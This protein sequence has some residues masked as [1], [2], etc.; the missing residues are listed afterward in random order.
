MPYGVHSN[1][2]VGLA[3]PRDERSV[4]DDVTV[5]VLSH[6]GKVRGRWFGEGVPRRLMGDWSV[7]LGR[8]MGCGLGKKWNSPGKLRRCRFTPRS[9]SSPSNA[10]QRVRISADSR[11]RPF[12]R[13]YPALGPSRAN[14][15][16]W[17]NRVH[18][19]APRDCTYTISSSPR[20][21]KYPA[22]AIWSTLSPLPGPHVVTRILR[23][24]GQDCAEPT[25]YRK[26]RTQAG[27]SAIINHE[28]IEPF[29]DRSGMANSSRSTA[30]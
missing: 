28:G 13:S 12:V 4:R 26:R 5:F 9:S 25:W 14:P 19:S 18:C 11:I 24:G 23:T 10:P 27:A 20:G 21:V 6:M 17:I 15:A 16:R 1:E 7:R 3:R 22:R 29:N 30:G 2:L 8:A